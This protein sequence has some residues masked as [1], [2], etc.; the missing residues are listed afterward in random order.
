MQSLKTMVK[1]DAERLSRKVSVEFDTVCRDALQAFSAAQAMGEVVKNEEAAQELRSNAEAVISGIPQL[2]RLAAIRVV[3]EQQRNPGGWQD[4]VKG[5]QSFYAAMKAGKVPDLAQRPAMEAQAILNGIELVVEGNPIPAEA[6]RSSAV[7]CLQ[8]PTASERE[9]WPELCKRALKRYRE[10]VG[11]SRYQLAESRLVQVKVESTAVH[12]VEAGLIEWCTDRLKSVQPRTVKGQLDCMVSA[13]RGVLPKLQTPYLK[14]LKGVML[15]RTSDRQ[16]MPLKAI[17]EA[18][19][20]FRNRPASNKVR[21]G[22]E[23]GAS[24][25]D[26][27][28]VEVLAV[29]GMK[30]RELMEA[31]SSALYS[32]TDVFGQEGL[33]FR[34]VVGKNKASEREIPLSDGTREVVD[35]ARLRQMLEWQD[36]NHREAHSA[37]SSMGTRFGKVTKGYTLYQMRHTWKDVAVHSRVD[38]ELRERI[39]GHKVRGVAAVYGSGIPLREGLAALENIRA[40]L[41]G[42]E[43]IQI[44]NMRA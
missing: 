27:I 29:L 2:M 26:A 31:K 38:F 16:S 1:R 8:A 10:H 44:E 35:V 12:H 33:Y 6:D 28:A 3:E 40:K 4:V 19:S 25:F 14:E 13:L 9:T 15:P 7:E 30:P 24:Q 18:L 20:F 23:G 17:Q 11:K 39:L 43:K 32:K 22:Y 42:D 21:I 5:W 37:V 34:V 41:L 36:R